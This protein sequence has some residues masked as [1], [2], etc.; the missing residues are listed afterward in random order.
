MCAK[1]RIVCMIEEGASLQT[2]ARLN[3]KDLEIDE[4]K[5]RLHRVE[6]AQQAVAGIH[7][8]KGTYRHHHHHHHRRNGDLVTGGCRGADVEFQAEQGAS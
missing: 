5:K 4:L 3:E 1:P 8:V 2:Q 7:S 6:A